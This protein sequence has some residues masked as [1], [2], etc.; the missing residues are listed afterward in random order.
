MT[1]D[2]ADRLAK[3][4][5]IQMVS[6]DGV[7]RPRRLERGGPPTHAVRQAGGKDLVRAHGVVSHF[8]IH[9]IVE[10]IRAVI[11]EEAVETAFCPF[12][13]TP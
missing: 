6:A 5:A 9:Y 10:T 3:G 4:Y 8:A 1:G 11:P 12:C 7:E 13:R 2:S